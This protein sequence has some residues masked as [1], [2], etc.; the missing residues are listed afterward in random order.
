[1]TRRWMQ[2]VARPSGLAPRR[3]AAALIPAVAV[4]V[5]AQLALA[6]RAASAQPS[7]AA[8]GEMASFFTLFPELRTMPAPP[9]VTPGTRASY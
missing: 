6:S 1:M 5:I 2:P 3:R 7:D 4:L 9:W 8:I